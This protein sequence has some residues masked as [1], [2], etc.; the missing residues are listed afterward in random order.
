MRHRIIVLLL[1]LTLPA[2]AHA[3]ETRDLIAVA[4]MPL[5]VAAVAEATDVP[6]ADLASVVSSMNRAAVPAPQFV[7]VIR[8]TPVALVDTRIEPRFVTWASS[9]ADSGLRGDAYA[10]ALADRLDLYGVEEVRVIEPPVV[11]PAMVVE[12]QYV[13]ALV[14]NRVA[15]PAID[16]L[17]II[18]MPLAVAAVADLAGVS[19]SDLIGFVT[20]LNQASVPPPQFVEIVRYVPVA[21]VEDGP[22]FVPWVTQQVNRGVVSNDLALTV[23]DR[24]RTYGIT[25][26]EVVAPRRVVLAEDL[27]PPRITSRIA[28][29]PHGGPPG[30][31]KKEQ[32]VRTGAEIVH[33]TGRNRGE[34]AA[35]V[36]A[37]DRA[38]RRDVREKRR[39]DRER[40]RSVSDDRKGPGKARV[41]ASRDRERSKERARAGK[42]ER[43]K[44]GKEHKNRGRNH[45]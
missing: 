3:L 38:V 33:G 15:S 23:A 2:A 36:A 18:A 22:D 41:S 1:L 42:H 34:P 7:E 8:Y 31:L 16:P 35:R 19:R 10:R 43:G 17:S 20:A 28:R 14:M 5:A 26:V 25:E 11:R 37:P 27:V 40:G 6:V 30:L 39:N 29:H 4:A 44:G 21:L 12:R 9:T 45:L 13:P 32:G 24:Y